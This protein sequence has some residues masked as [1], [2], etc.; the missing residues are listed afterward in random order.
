MKTSEK[1][2]SLKSTSEMF[3]LLKY[4][5]AWVSPALPDRPHQHGARLDGRRL[6][7]DDEVLHQH[8]AGPPEGQQR[9]RGRQV[10]VELYTDKDTTWAT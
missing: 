2:F 3:S 9:P 8:Q 4:F 7:G 10:R 1:K 5:Q 6:R